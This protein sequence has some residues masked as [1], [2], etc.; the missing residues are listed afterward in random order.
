M[1]RNMH[2]TIDKIA[3]LTRRQGKKGL[4][5]MTFCD[6]LNLSPST[7]YNYKKFVVHRYPDIIEERGLLLAI[8]AEQI[9]Q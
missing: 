8:P 4:D 9:G 6:M 5:I 1:K 2:T 7:W 3:K